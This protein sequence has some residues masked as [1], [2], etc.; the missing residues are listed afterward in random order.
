MKQTVLVFGLIAGAVLAAML[1]ITL[2]L[3]ERIG[4]DRAELIGYTSMV[5]AFLLVYFGVRSYRDSRAGGAIGFAR[6]LTAG[7][8]IVVVASLVYVLAWQLLYTRYA[9]D[10]MADYQAHIVEKARA[11]GASEESIAETRRELDAFADLYREPMA[12][13]AITFIEPLPV[14]LVIALVSAGVLSRRRKL[15]AD[16]DAIALAES[17]MP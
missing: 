1:V 8:L 6:A 9:P 3:H 13:A 14:G 16:I 4:F 5:L 7:S 11:V 10:F 2:T 15:R 12:R 17:R